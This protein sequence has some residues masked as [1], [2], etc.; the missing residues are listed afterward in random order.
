MT[1]F[2]FCCALAALVLWRLGNGSD[3]RVAAEIFAK[4]AAKDSHTGSV[5]DAD[6]WKSGEEG[7]IEEAFDLGLG[8]VCSAPDDVD[9]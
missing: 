8:F 3:V 6:A 1:E 5:H 9:L 2:N 4:G 7:T